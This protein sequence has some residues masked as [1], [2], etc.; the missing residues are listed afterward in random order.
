[1][2][3]LRRL[4]SRKDKKLDYIKWKKDDIYEQIY[5]IQSSKMNKIKPIGATEPLSPEYLIKYQERRVN[6][7]NKM[8]PMKKQEVLSLHKDYLENMC[9][10]CQYEFTAHRTIGTPCKSDFENYCM[11]SLISE[12]ID[13]GS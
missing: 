13:N 12:V 8:I 7:L 5:G 4:L 3:I 11:T 9:M 10:D 6:I 2:N 1:M